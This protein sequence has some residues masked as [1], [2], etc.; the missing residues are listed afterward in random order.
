MRARAKADRGRDVPLV[1]F[2]NDLAGRTDDEC[3]IEPAIWELRNLLDH[4]ASGNE[5]IVLARFGAEHLHLRAGNGD[6]LLHEAI[7]SVLPFAGSCDSL[8]EI[9]RK[10]DQACRQLPRVAHAEV[11]Q[12]ADSVQILL[13]GRTL[14]RDDHMRLD[15]QRGVLRN[16]AGRDSGIHDSPGGIDT[17]IFE[18]DIRRDG[19]HGRY[20]PAGVAVRP[21]HV[22]ITD[23]RS[24]MRVA[25][26][27]PERAELRLNSFPAGGDPVDEARIGLRERYTGLDIF[28]EYCTAVD[29]RRVLLQLGQQY[30]MSVLHT[31]IGPAPAVRAPIG[32]IGVEDQGMAPGGGSARIQERPAGAP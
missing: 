9:L 15:D 12:V 6:G 25:G 24:V 22:E 27:G 16:L 32:D 30:L 8:Q 26:K 4:S 13:D 20:T 31:G 28:A 2:E 17:E 1:V 14:L 5:Q 23:R 29:V 19:A 18:H 11:D 10:H 7:D 3:G 21:R